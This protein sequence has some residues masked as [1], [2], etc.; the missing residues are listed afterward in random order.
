MVFVKNLIVGTLF[1]LVMFSCKG[2]NVETFTFIPPP[3]IEI[4]EGHK[5]VSFNLRVKTPTDAGDRD[6]NNRKIFVRQLLVEYDVDIVGTQEGL[7]V[8]IE[9]IIDDP[10]NSPYAYTGVGR[11]D[12]N[13]LGKP[14]LYYTK[15]LNINYWITEHFGCQKHQKLHPMVL[16]QLSQDMYLG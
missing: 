9:D 13:S 4:L 10:E 1:T 15:K 6:W 5:I 3:E 11:D 16:C 8:Q 7:L 2:S 12:G 14:V